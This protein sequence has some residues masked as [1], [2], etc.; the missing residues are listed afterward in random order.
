MFKALQINCFLTTKTI[1]SMPLNYCC[2]PHRVLESDLFLYTGTRQVS[3]YLEK[4]NI[5]S[6]PNSELAEMEKKTI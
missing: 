2:L 5:L 6:K 4:M 3:L 1:T